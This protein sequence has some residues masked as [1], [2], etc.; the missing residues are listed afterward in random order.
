M[1]YALKDFFDGRV[2]LPYLKAREEKPY[3]TESI[4]PYRPIPDLEYEHLVGDYHKPILA[5]FVAFGDEGV[6]R[7]RDGV[8]KFVEKLRPIKQSMKLDGE[9]YIK[10]RTASNID[11]LISRL[12]DDVALVYDGV[13]ARTEA[14]R[15]QIL[16][17]GKLKVSENGVKFTVDYGIPDKNKVT[18]TIDWSDTTNAKPITDM[19]NWLE[20]LDW[21]P[22]GGIVSSTVMR[23]ILQNENVKTMV[24]GSDKADRP[25]APSI[26]NDFLMTYD[27]PPLVVNK[28]KV[29]DM[30][31]NEISL[32][33]E[34][35][36]TWVGD[37]IGDTLMGP[38]EESVLGKG[39]VRSENGAF[40][41]VYE[42][43]KPVGIFTTGTA[44]S[45][46]ALPG[47]DKILIA[48]VI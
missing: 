28:D 6:Y 32:W 27:L 48:T 31:K 47:A 15:C 1:A 35:V 17:T 41:Q 5:S 19:L 18:P 9:L 40:V 24:W 46:V 7:G 8:S 13:R 12:F 2:I 45:L 33:P 39:I 29:R 26:L 20:A 42:Q 37:E 3:V 21:T 16:S 30:D 43:E 36:M 34:K 44:T 23:Y 25:L 14:M 38:T 22:V 4:L 11:P 10:Y